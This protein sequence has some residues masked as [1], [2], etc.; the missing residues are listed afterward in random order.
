MKHP[1]T[2]VF[3]LV[4]SLAMIACLGGCRQTSEQQLATSISLYV[5][6]VRTATSLYNAKL[7]TPQ[8]ADAFEAARKA[9]RSGLDAWMACLA[10]GREDDIIQ[11]VTQSSLATM[12]AIRD[13]AKTRTV[14]P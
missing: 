4:V 12:V 7:L 9:A 5:T 3:L 10:E 14:K 1:W 11:A 6:A 2:V 13:E 8:E